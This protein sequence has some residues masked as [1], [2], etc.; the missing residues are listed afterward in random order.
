MKPL[1][2]SLGVIAFFV[3]IILSQGCA[4]IFGSR[5][6][7]MVF[8]GGEEMQAKVFIDDT[9]RGEAP[10]KIV[11]PG[12]L[13]QHGSTLEIRAE[14]YKTQEYLILRKPHPGYIIADFAFGAVPLIIDMGNGYA[15]RPSPRKFELNPTKQD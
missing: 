10:G 2:K 3:A 11:L 1:F 8:T 5:T 4:T 7:T 12:R 9:L 6:N 14:G 15:L 13:I